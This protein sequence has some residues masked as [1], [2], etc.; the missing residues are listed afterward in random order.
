MKERPILFNG[1]MVRA[2]LA[3]TKTQTRRVVKPQWSADVETVSERPALDPILKCVVGGHSGEWEDEHG[4][5]EVRRCPYGSG[6]ERLWVRET[7]AEVGSFDPPLTVTRADYPGCVPTFYENVPPAA[8]VRWKPAIFMRRAQSR[9]TLE[10]T[11]VRV[12]RLNGITEVDAIAEGLAPEDAFYEGD[13][14]GVVSARERYECLWESINGLG[15]WAK[16][17]WVW[18]IEFKRVL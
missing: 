3:G 9:I 2:L 8:K 7:F 4:L 1:K 10:V 15:S 13:H 5:D 17:P 12:E 11:G 6:G 16:N 18:V 14:I